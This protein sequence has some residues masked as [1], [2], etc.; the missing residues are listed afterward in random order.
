MKTFFPVPAGGPSRFK[1]AAAL[2]AGAVLAL[3]SGAASALET[4]YVGYT[5]GCFGLAC[6]PPGAPGAQTLT[7]SGLTYNNSTFNAETS[8]GFVS[9]G[10]TG[11]TTPAGNFNNLGSFVLTGNPHDYIGNNFDLLVTFTAPPGTAPGT[12]LFTDTIVGSVTANNQGGVF[13][14]FNNA[15]QHFT[16]AGGGSFDFF[17]NDVSLTAGH[18]IGVSG[19]ILT[20]VAAI[21]EPETYALF[22]AGLAAVGFMSRRRKT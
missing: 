4:T 18:S 7:L 8:G 22:M 16:F 14:N 6:V 19:T 13:I 10:S 15:P 11:A 17:V 1:G 12:G 2:V 5:D 9:L 21:P 3:G 20:T